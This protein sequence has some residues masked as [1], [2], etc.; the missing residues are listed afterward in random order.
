MK[1]G[2]ALY[3]DEDCIGPAGAVLQTGH[4][5]AAALVARLDLEGLGHVA[6][7]APGVSVLHV[8]LRG[9]GDGEAGG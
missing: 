4:A 7:E 1:Q 5:E 8:Q 6:E 3:L 2:A 9:V